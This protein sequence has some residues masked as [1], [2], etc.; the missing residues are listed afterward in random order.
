VVLTTLVV[1]RFH[2]PGLGLRC[3]SSIAPPV[4]PLDPVDLAEVWVPAL[5][6]D[7]VSAAPEGGPDLRALAEG[8]V[9][10]NQ[11]GLDRVDLGQADS[12]QVD[13]DQAD[14]NPADLA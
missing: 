12:S 10:S 2:L 1:R 5:L 4:S 13:S 8:L 7:P 3:Q 6:A 14:L 11:A 9:A